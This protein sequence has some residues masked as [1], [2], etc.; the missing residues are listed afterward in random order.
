MVARL[1]CKHSRSLVVFVWGVR[2]GV[3]CGYGH[4][5]RVERPVVKVGKVDRTNLNSFPPA[6][7]SR[8]NPYDRVVSGLTKLQ[9]TVTAYHS[10]FLN[11]RAMLLQYCDLR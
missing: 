10:E 1:L 11:S 4:S 2:Y 5:L 6:V 3:R 8:E 9:V 7:L